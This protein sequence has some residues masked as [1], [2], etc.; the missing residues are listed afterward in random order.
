MSKKS[1]IEI[2]T[3]SI[4]NTYY[5]VWLCDINFEILMSVNKLLR[6]FYYNP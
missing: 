3:G 1:N 5:K 2:S 6:Y 4:Y